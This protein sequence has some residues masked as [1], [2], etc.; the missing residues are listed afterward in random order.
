MKR[1]HRVTSEPM[2]LAV[3][4]RLQA[5][6]RLEVEVVKGIRE[7]EPT[8]QKAVEEQTK[9]AVKALEPTI[10]FGGLT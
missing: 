5:S 8:I 9:Q 3:A 4:I 10:I 1:L 6:L 2:Y 7:Q